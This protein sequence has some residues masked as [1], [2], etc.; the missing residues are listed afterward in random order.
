M[1]KLANGREQMV[2]EAGFE[3]SKDCV[4]PV[5]GARIS[6]PS[7]RRLPTLRPLTHGDAWKKHRLYPPRVHKFGTHLSPF[8]ISEITDIPRRLSPVSTALIISPTNQ[9]KENLLIG[10]GG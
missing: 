1:P 2:D 5:Q 10:S 8:K 9:R 7:R 6:V 4:Q 3:L